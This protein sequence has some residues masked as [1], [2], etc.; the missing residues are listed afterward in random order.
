MTQGLQALEERHAE[1]L[2]EL[3]AVQQGVADI[4]ATRR[5][6]ERQLEVLAEQ[7]EALTADER[8]AVE[9]GRDDLVSR[10]REL[11]GQL[12][13]KYAE[14][15]DLHR[16][17]VQTETQLIRSEKQARQAVDELTAQK[18]AIEGHVSQLRNLLEPD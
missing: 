14:L 8:K 11:M 16:E 1:L 13:A 12:E 15:E 9:K 18:T 2:A 5:T 3:A 6:F 4:G 17:A 10:A 7:R